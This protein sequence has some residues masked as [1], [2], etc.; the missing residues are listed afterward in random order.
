M[1]TRA[2]LPIMVRR[3]PMRPV[4]AMHPLLGLTDMG[5]VDAAGRAVMIAVISG[6]S[7]RG[8]YGEDAGDIRKNHM[9]LVDTTGWR[10]ARPGASEAVLPLDPVFRQ[11]RPL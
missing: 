9:S 5:P 8:I 6:C 7:P 3:P 10:S 2:L 4:T 11:K 1:D